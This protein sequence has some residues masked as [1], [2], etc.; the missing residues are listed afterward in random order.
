MVVALG[1]LIVAALGLLR[2][3]GGG[4]ADTISTRGQSRPASG[5]VAPAPAPSPGS[6]ATSR[7]LPALPPPPDTETPPDTP[8][9]TPTPAQGATE[10][11]PRVAE[12]TA[13]PP[14]YDPCVGEDDDVDCHGGEAN[15]PAYAHDDVDG[16]DAD[17]DGQGCE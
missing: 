2:P 8:P 16:L 12:A 14:S 17:H 5:T 6:T 3:V 10:L 4:T 9:P 1:A 13:C 11:P 7:A 15:G